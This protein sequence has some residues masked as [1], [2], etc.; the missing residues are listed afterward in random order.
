M[1]KAGKPRLY[2]VQSNIETEFTSPIFR[3]DWGASAKLILFFCL[4]LG[5]WGMLALTA[6]W[7]LTSQP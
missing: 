4:S 5:I 2:L 6:W 7:M 3:R 1:T